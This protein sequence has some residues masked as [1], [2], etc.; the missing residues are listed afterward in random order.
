[1]GIKLLPRKH[2]IPAPN[3]NNLC[4]IDKRVSSHIIHADAAKSE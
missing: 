3:Q 4:V 2:C 1:M